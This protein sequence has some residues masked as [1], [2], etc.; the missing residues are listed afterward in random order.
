MSFCD[1]TKSYFQIPFLFLGSF[2]RQMHHRALDS[3]NKLAYAVS[4]ER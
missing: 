1:I 4:S 3:P 2:E